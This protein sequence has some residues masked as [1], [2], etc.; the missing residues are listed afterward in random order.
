MAHVGW[1][2][3]I[4]RAAVSGFLKEGV[5]LENLGICGKIMLKTILKHQ[6]ERAWIGWRDVVNGV[7]NH[8]L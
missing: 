3:N 2:R 1:K 5:Q 4:Y 6:D 7:I 8:V